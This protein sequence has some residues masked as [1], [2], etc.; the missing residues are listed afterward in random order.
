MTSDEFSVLALFR[1]YDTD[2]YQMLFFGSNNCKLSEDQLLRAMRS[3]I[4]RGFVAKER[5]QRAYSLTP[6]GYRISITRHQE[7][8]K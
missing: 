3:L 4:D 6:N 7:V 5:P 8:R 2:P 1:Q